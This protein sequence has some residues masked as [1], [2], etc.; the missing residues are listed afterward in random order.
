MIDEACHAIPIGL[1]DLDL[2]DHRAARLAP[3]QIVHAE[4][5]GPGIGM[6]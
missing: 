3:A 5:F 6:S 1:A 2:P 4:G